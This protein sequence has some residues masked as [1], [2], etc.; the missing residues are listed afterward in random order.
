MSPV[1]PRDPRHA[2]LRGPALLL[3]ALFLLSGCAAFRGATPEPTPLDFPG[4]AGQLALHGIEVGSP[5][6]GDAG[7]TDATLIP[8][9]IGFD[10]AGLDQA[11]TVRV[12]VYIFRNRETYERRRPDV[13]ACVAAWATDPATVEFVDASPYVVAIQGPVG[14]RFK[15]ALRES[16]TVAAGN[17]G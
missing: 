16:L 4:I 8:T 9:A 11:A 12:R 1:R 3:A 5:I 17:G 10:A 6:A 7:C 2:A 13:D 14:A 15:T